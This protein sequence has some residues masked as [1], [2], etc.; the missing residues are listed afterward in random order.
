MA[1][2]KRCPDRIRPAPEARIHRSGV[3]RLCAALALA[4]GAWLLTAGPAMAAG[5]VGYIKTAVGKV[6][7]SQDGATRGAEAGGPVLVNDTI[8]TGGEG[9][10]GLVFDDGSTLSLGPGSRLT[11]DEMVYD[12]KASEVGLGLDLV[13]GVMLYVSGYIAKVDPNSVRVT[14][15]VAT[16]G[17][18]GTRFLLK[19]D[20]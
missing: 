8:E 16:I 3:K 17:I 13:Q 10:I 19:V 6:T 5:P 15:P 11:V 4:T 1:R 14:T 2:A 7:L 18:R 12:P 20:P 9:R